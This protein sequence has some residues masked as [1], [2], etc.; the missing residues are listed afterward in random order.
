MSIDV[1][2]CSNFATYL[3]HFFLL[4]SLESPHVYLD[5]SP[6]VVEPP[7]HG[8]STICFFLRHTGD[9]TVDVCGDI[10]QNRPQTLEKRI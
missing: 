10:G 8:R 1:P 7:V 3:G 9:P 2:L 6:V 5:F 4:N